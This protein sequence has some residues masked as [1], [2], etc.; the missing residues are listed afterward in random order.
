MR[1]GGPLIFGA[2]IVFTAFGVHR[3]LDAHRTADRAPAAEA[4]PAPK[5]KS[6]PVVAKAPTAA[7][8]PITSG[9]SLWP[10]SGERWVYRFRRKA[11]VEFGGKPW[12]RLMLGGRVAVEPADSARSVVP[13]ADRFYLL[14]FEVDRMEMQGQ[15]K[16][17]TRTFPGV[18]VEIDGAGKLREL[19]FVAAR[20]GA[21]AVTQEEGDLL[22]DLTAQ[23][24]FFENKTR[25]GT[26][27]AEWSDLGGTKSKGN[28]TVTKRIIRYKN[29]PEISKLDSTHEWA[30]ESDAIFGIRVGRIEGTENFTVASSGGDF[31]QATSYRW[32]WTTT[33]K[34]NAPSALAVRDAFTVDEI[35]GGGP[36]DP[37]KKVDP[38]RIARE[39]ATLAVLAPHARLKLFR[40]A[41]RALDAGSDELVSLIVKELQGKN[42]MSIEWRTG[43]GALAASSNPAAAAALL[44]LY[45]EP[46]RTFDEKL[47]ILSGVTAG[48]GTPAPEWKATFETALSEAAANPPAGPYGPGGT[49]PIDESTA[50]TFDPSRTFDPEAAIREASLYALGSSIRKETNANRRA[51]LETVLWREV[52][53]ATTEKAQAMVLEAIGNSGSG[54]YYGY[55]KEEFA[56]GSVPVRAKAVAAVRFLAPELAQPILDQA[57]GDPAATV[58]KVAAW[59]AKF[60]AAAKE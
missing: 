52:K 35:G 29:H 48:E 30:V 55:V 49:E 2:A 31:T 25:L 12:L 54:V 14:S 18:R 38:A 9:D 10:N 33:E 58:R 37:A 28:R 26:A 16:I 11:S 5:V 43:I 1:Y 20:E 40:G 36:F 42:S 34:V 19:R 57:K 56:A 47:S 51:D 59:S 53:E 15:S 23:W 6:F 7:S 60:Q 17:E 13:G 39:W 4:V 21:G 32:V 46:G 22:R 44:K 41:K 45:R 50:A 3:G 27:E 24:L 8:D